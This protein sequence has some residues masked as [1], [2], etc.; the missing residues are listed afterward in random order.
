MLVSDQVP[1]QVPEQVLAGMQQ[2]VLLTLGPCWWG[3]ARVRNSFWVPTESVVWVVP[4]DDRLFEEY[5]VTV[6]YTP[7]Q[8][9]DLLAATPDYSPRAYIGGV[10]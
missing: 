9:I 1:E 5:W 7:P 6:A 2:A 10:P 4:S 8:Y 3:C